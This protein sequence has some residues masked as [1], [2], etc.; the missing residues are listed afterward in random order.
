MQRV[1]PGVGAAFG[2]VEEALREGFVPALFRGLTEGLPTRE[3]TCLPVKQAGLAIPDPVKTAP[4]NWTASCVITGHLV[5]ALRGQAAFRTANHTACLRGGRLSVR[6][7]GEQRAEEA[8]TAALEGVPVLQ[9]RQMLRAANTGA[10]LTVLP[11]TV[12]GTDLG[13]QEWRDALFL[14]YGLELP[15]LPTHCDG[16]EARFTISHALDCKK[17]GLVTAR[18]NELNDG[19]ADLAG[20]AF[21]P[22][23][24]RDNPL[25]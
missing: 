18:H 1:T 22:A 2:P 11:S 6:H 21:T 23:R 12:N 10:W 25:I 15:D 9:A 14:R 24:V 19:V 3:N 16:C 7:R 17:G 20:K 5:A 4:E 8:S 13:A